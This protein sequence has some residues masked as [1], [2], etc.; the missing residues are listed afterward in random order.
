MAFTRFVMVLR[1]DEF[2]DLRHRLACI[3]DFLEE[4]IVQK[5]LLKTR[6]GLDQT[7]LDIH[8]S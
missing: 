2:K 6:L 8:H 7:D 4:E 3:N 1:V 5:H